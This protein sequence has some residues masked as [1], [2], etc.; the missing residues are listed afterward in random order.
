MNKDSHLIWENYS[1]SRDINL[2]IEQIDSP[3]ILTEGKLTDWVNTVV[4]KGQGAMHSVMAKKE[5]LLAKAQNKHPDITSKLGAVLN[6]NNVK[7]AAA[8]V[9]FLAAVAGGSSIAMDALE[10]WQDNQDADQQL[11]QALSSVDQAKS[12]LTGSVNDP[13]QQEMMG[14]NFN[15]EEFQDYL[16]STGLDPDQTKQVLNAVKFQQA[17]DLSSV[18][19]MSVSADNTLAERLIERTNAQGQVQQVGETFFT[20]KVA[21][22]A[23]GVDGQ[24]VLLCDTTTKVTT[25]MRNT[26]TV[27]VE[28]MSGGLQVDLGNIIS[29]TIRGLDE[30]TQ[31]DIWTKINSMSF[32]NGVGAVPNATAQDGSLGAKLVGANRL[33]ESTQQE[34][35]QVVIDELT[36]KYKKAME[37]IHKYFVLQE[38]QKPQQTPVQQ[39]PGVA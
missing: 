27:N 19:D 8:V 5:E 22:Y 31:N 23:T 3:D 13:A 25:I 37:E 29:G 36:E 33:N 9:A 21:T 17:L 28:E 11:Q 4:K 6:T 18:I 2:L 12:D 24:K 38:V 26:V 39:T 15:L 10:T 35:Y 20:S 16:S 7:T 30:G 34:Q 14:V 32:E 1:Q